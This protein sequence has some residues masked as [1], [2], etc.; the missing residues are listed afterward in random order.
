MIDPLNNFQHFLF[1]YLPAEP[2]ACPCSNTLR[3]TKFWL[4]TIEHAFYGSEHGKD[5]SDEIAGH[6]KSKKDLAVLGKETIVRG[7]RT[8]L[9]TCKI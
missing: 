7:A 4:C 1:S 6:V 9:H 2:E 5:E 8:L 3:S